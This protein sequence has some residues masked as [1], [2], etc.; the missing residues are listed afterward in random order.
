[1]HQ[2]GAYGTVPMQL[3]NYHNPYPYDEEAEMSIGDYFLNKKHARLIAIIGSCS[4]A[5][6][7][8]SVS[9]NANAAVQQLVIADSEPPQT[10]DP[11][12]ANNS[13]VDLVNVP[14][15]DVLVDFDSNNKLGGRLATSWKVSSDG[16]EVAVSLR[17]GVEFHDGAPL[18]SADVK[19]TLDRI[20]KLN[21]GVASS[22]AVYS[23]TTIVDSKNLTINL[24]KRSATFVS[25]LS[26]AY[27]LNSKLVEKNAG[28]DS[29]QSWLGT[30]GAGS[31]PYSLVSYTANQEAVFTKNP[32]YWR[33]FTKQADK[34]I[35]RYTPQSATQRDLLKSGEIDVAMKIAT[36][37]LNGFKADSKF[38]VQDAPTIVQLYIHMN[39]MKGPLK[40]VKVRQAISLA[41][42]YE[43]HVRNIMGGNGAIAQG[44]LPKSI[45]CHAYIADGKQ[46]LAR[47]K[48]LLR[49]AKVKNLKLTMIYLSVIEE[50]ARG[51]LMLQSALK[52]IGVDLQLVTV[53]YPEYVSQ[54]SK[55]STTPDMGMISAF[56]AYPDADAVLRIVYDSANLSGGNN[57]A[58]SNPSVDTLVR[59]AASISDSSKRCALYREA[60]R[61][62]SKDYPS[63]YISNP[64][65]VTVRN[66]NVTGNYYRAAHH[67]TVDFFAMMLK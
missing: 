45:A 11:V 62:I 19:Y 52:S 40:D 44:P 55:P 60:Q 33:P 23:S 3:F 29:G 7:M 5:L 48:E 21:V 6:A 50:H 36:A 9:T 22:L 42:D 66:T 34:I 57:F 30:R 18:T 2:Y 32:N 17:G 39:T 49:Q 54:I 8:L 61:L 47:A 1:M 59:E 63:L 46:N 43:S 28:T 35:I 38:V 13:T 53:T 12:R 65:F 56:P 37:D 64:K 25:A 16:L 4:V 24:S 10:F 31:G 67:N 15:Y 58:Y 20:K 51:G 27:I 41:Y 26:R 14:L